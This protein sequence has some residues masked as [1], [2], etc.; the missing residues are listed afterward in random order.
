MQKGEQN[1]KRQLTAGQ[2]I[3]FKKHLYQEEKSSAT[4]EKYIRD[5]RAFYRFMKTKVIEK[6]DVILY[7]EELIRQYMPSSVNSMLSSINSFFDFCDWYE[8]KVKTLKIQKQIFL[9]KEKE[10][11]KSEYERLLNAAWKNKNKRLYYIMQTVCASGIR[12]SELKFINTDAVKNQR[13][14]VRCKGKIRYVILPKSLCMLLM[15]YIKKNKIKS[16]PIFVSKNGQP[17]NRTNIWK[18]MKQLCEAAKVSKTKVFPHNLRHLFARTF[19]SQQ[20]DIARL[21]DLLG[22]SSIN[23]TRIYTIESGEIHRRQIQK[24]GLVCMRA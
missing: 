13:A 9:N 5:I 6:D 3:L 8:L 24:M 4:I 17:L 14:A 19:Y 1:M 11:T 18:E 16:G 20:K 10:L 23:T 22:H 2:I 15:D 7:K 12:I 21:A